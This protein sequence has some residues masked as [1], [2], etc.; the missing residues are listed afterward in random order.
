LGGRILPVEG[1]AKEGNPESCFQGRVAK[2]GRGEGPF[3]EK[4]KRPG[5]G[6]KCSHVK[7]RGN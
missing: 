2:R 4:E 3:G 6:R 1:K 7:K 5:V